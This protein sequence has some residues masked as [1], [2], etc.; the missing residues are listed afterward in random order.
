MSNEALRSLDEDFKLG[1]LL[2][3]SASWA[4]TVAAVTELSV[5]MMAP[6]H[7]LF[8]RLRT[9]TLKFE[10]AMPLIVI[11]TSPV[12][13][14]PLSLM[15]LSLPQLIALVLPERETGLLLFPPALPLM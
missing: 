2:E 3:D 6:L 5:E 7:T 15:E 1:L 13:A 8:G 11:L 9:V 14:L 10:D 4:D 12:L